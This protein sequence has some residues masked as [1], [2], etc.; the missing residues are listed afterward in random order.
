MLATASSDLGVKLWDVATGASLDDRIGLSGGASDVAFSADGAMVAIRPR[1]GERRAEVWDVATAHVDRH[2]R[3]R[4]RQRR[5]RPSPSARTGASSR[6][7]ASAASC[8]SGTFAPGSSSASSTRAATV[9]S[10]SSSAETA[11]FSPSPDSSP[12]RRS[13]TSRPE[14]RSARSSPPEPQDDDRSVL[15]RAPAAG[16]ARQRPGGCLG[17]RPGVL[18]APGL[19]ARQPHADPRGVGGVPPRAALRARLHEPEPGSGANRP[20]EARQRGRRSEAAGA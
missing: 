2:V 4:A 20:G 10:R 15:R 8:A 17:Y 14:P 19:Q 11:G 16:D 1:A 18:E 9:R 7:V 6:S 3:R 5:L 13:G 12:S